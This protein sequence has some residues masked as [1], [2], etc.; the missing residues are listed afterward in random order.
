MLSNNGTRGEKASPGFFS[1]KA[2]GRQRRKRSRG[3][4]LAGVVLVPI[5]AF[6]IVLAVRAAAPAGGT[7]G[8]T[9]PTLNW[10]GTAV[11][12]VS[13]GEAS[14]V[15]GINCDTFT[16]NVSGIPT[17]Y[18]NTLISIKIQW[19]IPADDYDLYVHKDSN[20]GPVVAQGE[21][22]GAPATSDGTTIDPAATGTGVSAAARAA[23][24]ARQLFILFSC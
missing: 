3:S 7:I 22:G 4:A 13:A 17:D 24:I 1:G 5:L 16:L 8:P 23:I 20:A 2:T 12:G 11:G 19:T 14:C 10:T 9:G 18:T 15:E 21:N 6:G